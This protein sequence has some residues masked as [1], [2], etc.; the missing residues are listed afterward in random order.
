MFPMSSLSVVSAY[1]WTSWSPWLPRCGSDHRS[2]NRSCEVPSSDV[3]FCSTCGYQNVTAS[4]RVPANLPPCCES[5][6]VVI[7]C[8][9]VFDDFG[10][11]AINV[12]LFMFILYCIYSPAVTVVQWDICITCAE[13]LGTDLVSVNSIDYPFGSW[14]TW[15]PDCYSSLNVSGVTPFNQSRTRS[16][17]CNISSDCTPCPLDVETRKGL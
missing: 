7:S 6:S 14:S 5:E 8:E 11:C 1:S 4:Q 12:Y 9:E 13:L 3:P 10:A 16:R 15:K 17:E 2:R